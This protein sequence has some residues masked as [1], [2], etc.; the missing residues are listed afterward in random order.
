MKRNTLKTLLSA[1]MLTAGLAIATATAAEQ[2]VTPPKT[3][4]TV[5]FEWDSKY[6]MWKVKGDLQI[7]DTIKKIVTKNMN[8]RLEVEMISY[9]K[10]SDDRYAAIIL[11]SL[12]NVNDLSMEQR[13]PLFKSAGAYLYILNLKGKE[14]VLL[15]RKIGEEDAV[16]GGLYGS[17][18]GC[19]QDYIPIFRADLNHDGHP[20]VFYFTSQPNGITD[21]YVD[22]IDLHML[23]GTDFQ[24]VWNA[25]LMTDNYTTE[26]TFKY[27]GGKYAALKLGPSFDTVKPYTPGIKEYSK[28][29]FGDLNGDKKLDLLVWRR[30]YVALTTWKLNTEQFYLY[31]MSPDV[32]FTKTDLT[33]E[34][35][36]ALLEK[37]NLTWKQGF[38]NQNFCNNAGNPTDKPLITNIGDPVLKQ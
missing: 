7:V 21:A 35:G 31:T 20:E 29:Y 6:L 34:Q 37:N 10:V 38:P 28:L 9:T 18:Y 30:N 32:T 23:R 1:V 24:E 17:D 4:F 15:S 19:M 11:I 14:N 33:P 26:N 13:Q 36:H 5:K 12:G 22:S 8:S 3:D 16:T 27:T 25:R 2:Q